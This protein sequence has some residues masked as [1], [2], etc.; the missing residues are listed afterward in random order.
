VKFFC[1]DCGVSRF[2]RA[3]VL[4]GSGEEFLLSPET[5]EPLVVYHGTNAEFDEFEPGRSN[6]WSVPRKGFYFTDDPHAAREFGPTKAFRLRVRNP[7][8]LRDNAAWGDYMAVALRVPELAEAL[9]TAGVD[10]L[11]QAVSGGFAQWGEF[12][13]AAEE[14][15]YDGVIMPDRLGGPCGLHF[16]S[17]IVFRPSQVAGVR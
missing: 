4:I 3:Y 5:G 8:D 12:L 11:G 10:S 13:A 2:Y 17:Y 14:A 9:E 7:L 1:G 15:G 16:D 6:A